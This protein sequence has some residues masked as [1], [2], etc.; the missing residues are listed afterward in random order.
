VERCALLTITPDELRSKYGTEL[1]SF[2]ALAGAPA[3]QPHSE[4]QGRV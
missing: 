2:A 4:T 1:V 3:P